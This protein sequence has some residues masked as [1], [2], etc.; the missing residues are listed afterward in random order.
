MIPTQSIPIQTLLANGH[1]AFAGDVR[2]DAGAQAP[3]LRSHDA[4]NFGSGAPWGARPAPLIQSKLCSF[5][6]LPGASRTPVSLFRVPSARHEP[7]EPE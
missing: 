5:A 3:C 4:G 7:I 6:G 2:L 1:T